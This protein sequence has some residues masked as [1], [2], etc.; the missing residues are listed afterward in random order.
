MG[1]GSDPVICVSDGSQNARS[2]LRRG[3][4][5]RVTY[6]L[7][8]MKT[9]SGSPRYWSVRRLCVVSA[10]EALAADDSSH[11]AQIERELLM[12]IPNVHWST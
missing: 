7:S 4:Q 12:S 11:K 3:K 2:S 8:G 9:G 1:E 5:R 6:S 10:S